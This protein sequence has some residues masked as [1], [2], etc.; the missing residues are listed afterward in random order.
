MDQYKYLGIIIDSSLT[1]G[2]QL[3]HL[4]Q[5]TGYLTSNFYKMMASITGVKLRLEMWKVY[6]KSVIEYCVESYILLPSKLEQI[7]TLYYQTLR[8]CLSVPR[9]TARVDLIKALGIM[10]LKTIAEVRFCRVA[11]KLVRRGLRVPD[12]VQSKL[13]SIY[14]QFGHVVHLG[15]EIQ[16]EE[17]AEHFRQ[18]WIQLYC[19]Q[20]ISTLNYPRGFYLIKD[21][22][23]RSLMYTLLHKI[24]PGLKYKYL[25]CNWCHVEVSQTHIIDVCP[26]HCEARSLLLRRM[27]QAGLHDV[28]IG[29]EAIIMQLQSHLQIR[30]MPKLARQYTLSWIKDYLEGIRVSTMASLTV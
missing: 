8:R 5:R 2:A 27:S 28:A 30:R 1:M 18:R 7:E 19:G 21:N 24:V 4:K 6:V 10:D 29:I 17:L 14:L 12:S 22:R 15:E 26:Q 25:V 16:P 9:N 11:Q 23:D 3:R 20:A 13:E